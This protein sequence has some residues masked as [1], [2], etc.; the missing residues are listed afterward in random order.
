VALIVLAAGAA[1]YAYIVDR[2]QVSDADR[3]AR[4]RDVFPSFRVDQVSRVELGQN[5]DRFVLEREADA[6]PSV[7]TIAAPRRERADAQVTVRSLA[8][9]EP[10]D[11]A[12]VD[13]LLRELEL[14]TRVRDVSETSSM[15]LS[16]PR[17]RGRVTVGTLHY[18]FALGA[19]APRPEGGAYMRVDGQGSFVATRSLKVQL[20]RGADTYRDRTVVTLGANEVARL[21]VHSADGG[22][23]SLVRAGDGFRVAGAQLR[24]SRSATDHIFSTLAE[25]R[26]DSFLD[27]GETARA[28]ATAIAVTVAPRDE[29]RPL[30]TLRVGGTC[31][32][33]PDDVVL[34]RTSPSTLSVCTA[35][36]LVDA[37]NATPESLIDRALL[38][39]H[40]DEIERVRL[41]SVEHSGSI[42]ELVRKGSGWRER[43]PED[44]DLDS[45]E[46]DSANQL[47]LALTRAQSVEAP[48]AGA[49]EAGFAVRTRATIIRTGGGSGEVIELGVPSGDHPLLARRLNDGAIVRLPRSVSRRFEPH[50]VA[51][52]PRAIW[53]PAPDAGAVVAIDNGCAPALEHIELRE[54]R[55]AV[56]APAGFPADAQLVVDL[57][58][59]IARARAEAWV[60]EGDDGGFGFDRPG[61]CTVTLTLD[62]AGAKPGDRAEADTGGQRVSLSF[63]AEGEG[64]VYARAFGDAAVFLAPK[65]LR[66]LV[67]HPAVDRG[68]LRLDPE[69]LKSV[70]L[71]RTGARLVLERAG[72]HL[73][74]LGRDVGDG[75]NDDPIERA[76]AGLYA[77]A[78]VHTGPGRPGEG[79]N[80]PTLEIT[81]RTTASDAS[82]SETRILIGA[83][84]RVDD[85]EVYF[86]RASG[87]DATFAVP[88]RTVSAIL[89]AW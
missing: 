56:R 52:R 47:V 51:L 17:V 30:L 80:L 68:R 70:T 54:G 62:Q 88:R 32:G 69:T 43:T 26:A 27:D 6:G 48:R 79:M 35:K 28:T 50:P 53:R 2:H 40:A 77:S 85:A 76:L 58:A 24:A 38:F 71:V 75:G 57:I 65:E 8:S 73:V 13:L 9:L 45:E 89:D 31:P 49:A 64:G 20:L 42:V 59:A 66:E 4:E 34:Q 36:A 86:A 23:F 84:T 10:A 72:D 16:T 29:A 83:P 61:A 78:A 21:D 19:D 14:A 60:S 41:E 5:E 18:E 55:W 7:W 15:G 1:A 33:Q 63:G 87:V 81:A 44:R 37:V 74:R 22:G 46:S 82:F 12:A 25:A 67:S 39:A 11:G 3:A